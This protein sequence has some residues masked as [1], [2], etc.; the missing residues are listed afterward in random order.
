[1]KN[2]MIRRQFRIIR[3]NGNKSDW[4]ELSEWSL[5]NITFITNI[6]SKEC[7]DWQIEYRDV[8]EE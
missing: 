1:M 7:D 6:I 5:N 2:L 8:E 4:Y 3:S